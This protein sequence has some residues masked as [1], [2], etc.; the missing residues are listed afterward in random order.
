MTGRLATTLAVLVGLCSL[1][2]AAPGGAAADPDS[3][4]RATVVEEVSPIGPGGYLATGYRVAHRLSGATCRPRSSVTGNAYSCHVRF[5]YDP[6]WV[7]ANKPDVLC[8]AAPYDKT[9]TQ[10]R[11]ARFVRSGGLGKPAGLPWGLLL[12]NGER[13]TLIPGTFG[14]VHGQKIHYSYNDFRTVLVGPIDKSG[15]VWRIRVARNTGRFRFKITGWASIRKA[16]VGAP[17]RLE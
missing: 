4:A 7:S 16:W 3:G 5:G 6:C 11:V 13:T 2:A 1:I 12:A 15:P 14:V 10:L 9:V 17:S 8:L